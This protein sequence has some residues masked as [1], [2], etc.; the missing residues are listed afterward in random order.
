MTQDTGPEPDKTPRQVPRVDRV[1]DLSTD[2]AGA[3]HQSHAPAAA[4]VDATQLRAD[5]DALDAQGFVILENLI[6]T[7]EAAQAKAALETLLDPVGRNAFEGFHTQRAYALL[8]KTR[9][10]DALVAHPRVLA[11]VEH[12]VAPDPLLSACLAIKIHPGEAA[13]MAHVDDGFYPESRPRRPLS[14]AAIW[15]LDP[16]TADNGATVAWPGSHRWDDARRPTDAD[17]HQAVIMPAGSAVVFSGTLWHGGGAN[18]SDAPR[19]AL[20]PQYCAPWLRT[21]ENMSLAVSPRTVT[22]LSEELK[23][24]L[25]YNIRP[26][27]MGHVNG[28]HP[29]RL[30]EKFENDA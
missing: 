10:V 2:L 20:T 22:G 17:P 5:S 23:R 26:P 27:F 11:L 1:E 6:C 13:Q 18:R 16:F 21:Q 4:K 3:Y 24:L 19:L 8:E 7:D 30:L 28:M 14:A 15:A 29:K 9:A 25:G 12:A